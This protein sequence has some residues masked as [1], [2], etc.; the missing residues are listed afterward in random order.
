MHGPLSIEPDILF[1]DEP[2][3]ALDAVNRKDI[4]ELLVRLK[5]SRGLTCFLITHNLALVKDIGSTVAVMYPWQ[6]S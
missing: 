1:L 2:L 6:D 3:S 4:A 5:E